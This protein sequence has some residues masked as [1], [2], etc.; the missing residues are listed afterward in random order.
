MVNKHFVYIVY[1]VFVLPVCAL[2]CLCSNISVVEA[3]EFSKDS[4]F[5]VGEGAFFT[6]A[7]GV[8][9]EVVVLDDAVFQP[10][11]CTECKQRWRDS[12]MEVLV[13]TVKWNLLKELKDVAELVC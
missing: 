11:Q 6:P 2:C 4:F 13:E 12:G 1:Q 5:L 10:R 7:I 3:S 8:N 9:I